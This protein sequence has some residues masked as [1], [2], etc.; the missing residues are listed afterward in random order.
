MSHLVDL[1]GKTVAMTGC[2]GGIGK[3]LCRHLLR[4]GATLVLIDRSKDRSEALRQNLETEFPNVSLTAL[5]ADMEDIVSVKAVCEELERMPL[6]ILILN[7]GAYSIPRHRTSLSVDN[8]FQINALAPYYMTKRLLPTLRR[9]G[10]RVVAVGSIAHR[11]SKTDR[12]DVDFKTRSAA[13]LVYGNA[14][15]RLMFSL[16][17]L[18]RAETDV[19]L[20]V[21]HPG[22]TLTN[23]TAHYPKW[24]FALIKYPMKVL[25]M[26][27]RK[28]ALSIVEGCVTP[29][30]YREW[31][32]PR[33]L[34]IWGLP[35]KAT[36]RSCKRDEC[37]AIYRE[38]ET[39]I[40]EKALK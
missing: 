22:I 18:F 40:K 14:K 28:A 3:E 5:Y 35:R 9:R 36:L 4:A 26:S 17:E 6:D 25:F 16:Y 38:M 31:I 23:I 8:V 37:Q 32:G 29:C 1:R 12:A 34:D 2:T 30:G 27:P 15:R 13:S 7:A 39:C 10:G 24:V 20:A 19:A 33:W 11:Y 21:C